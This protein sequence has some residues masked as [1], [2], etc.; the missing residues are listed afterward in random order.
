MLRARL[1]G[2]IHGDTRPVGK[3]LMMEPLL[4]VIQMGDFGWK[5]HLERVVEVEPERLMILGG[6]HDDYDYLPTMPQCLGDFGLIP[7]TGSTMFVRG[8][9]SVDFWERILQERFWGKTWWPEE[10]MTH[11]QREQAILLYKDIKPRVMIT[12]EGPEAATASWY[13]TTITSRTSEMLDRMFEAHQPERWYFAH[14]HKQAKF[15]LGGT[16]FRCVNTNEI[17]EVELP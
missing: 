17:I 9:L 6:N 3:A 8:G 14:H 1:L 5:A 2:D 12:H 7:G 10:E 16:E 11:F 13:P 15:E 4:P